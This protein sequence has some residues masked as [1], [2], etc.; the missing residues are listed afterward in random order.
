MISLYQTIVIMVG[1]GVVAYGWIR[2]ATKSYD[3]TFKLEER[4]KAEQFERWR[5]E[6]NSVQIV[7]KDANK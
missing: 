6:Y 2:F 1:I 5:Q 7:G 4:K 3:G